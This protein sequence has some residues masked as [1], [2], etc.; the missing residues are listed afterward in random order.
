MED[1]HNEN[2]V[3]KSQYG[4]FDASQSYIVEMAEDIIAL[5]NSMR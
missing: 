2:A 1:W 5:V 4:K 3:V